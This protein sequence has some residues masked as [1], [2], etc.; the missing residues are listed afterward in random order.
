MVQSLLLLS[1]KL[2]FELRL[3][4]LLD[5]WLILRFT[6]GFNEKI[7]GKILLVLKETA[8][9]ESV[10]CNVVW[11]NIFRNHLFEHLDSLLDDAG[12]NAGL[13]HASVNKNS[14]LHTFSF[15]FIKNSKSFINMPSLLVDFSK[16]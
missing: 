3:V 14:R 8:L 9:D 2:E 15:H 11:L 5:V 16:D 13:N 12:L 1:R 6:D 7:Q 4:Q 10:V